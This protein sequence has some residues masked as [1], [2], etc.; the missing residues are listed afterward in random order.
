[1][2]RAAMALVLLVLLVLAGCGQQERP[3]SPG[4]EPS[5]GGG[6]TARAAAPE[7][8]PDETTPDETAAAEDGKQTVTMGG[9]RFRVEIDWPAER[10][11]LVKLMAGYMVAMRKALVA[12]DERYLRDVEFE[13]SAAPAAYD[14]LK[15]HTDREQT[16]R[17]V[18]RLYDLRVAAKMGKGAQVNVCVDET[19]ARVVSSRT[20]KAVSPRPSWV[21]APYLQALIAHRGDDGVWRIRGIRYDLKGCPA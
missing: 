11:P 4:G 1:M 9:G 15:Y 19:G 18:T 8:T 10:D 12:G 17:G 7:T 21:R 16:V 3:Y 20:G 2:R 6:G 14:W 13:L 5:A